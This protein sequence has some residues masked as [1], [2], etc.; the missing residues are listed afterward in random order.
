MR[1]HRITQFVNESDGRQTVVIA[2]HPFN[3]MLR[4]AGLGPD[5]DEGTHQ[6]GCSC[7]D[8]KYTRAV[9][10]QQE[11]EGLR[12]VPHYP[13]CDCDRCESEREAADAAYGDP[14]WEEMNAPS[15]RCA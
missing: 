6:P 10:E 3:H 11:Q 14:A 9:Q 1:L 7:D 13:T 15:E 5:L 2:D 4:A 8:C 12:N